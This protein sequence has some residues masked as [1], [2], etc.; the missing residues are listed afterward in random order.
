MDRARGREG[1]R[2]TDSD[3]GKE[4]KSDG[5]RS[6]KKETRRRIFGGAFSLTSSVY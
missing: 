3:R 4:N 2:Q 6:I 1:D 5:L